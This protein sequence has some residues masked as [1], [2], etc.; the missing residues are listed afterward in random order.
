MSLFLLLFICVCVN[1]RLPLIDT[2]VQNILINFDLS[3][4]SRSEVDRALS[5]GARIGLAPGGI[6]EMFEGYPKSG[7]L[8][9]EECV[10][11]NSR[12]GFIRMALKHNLPVVPI[13]CFG[14][15][16]LMRRLHFP[17]LE[18]MSNLLRVSICIF[19]GVC[20]L[21]IPFRKKLLY[22]VGKPI[23]PPEVQGSLD[24]GSPEFQR[25]VDEMHF[26][27]CESMTNLFEK[28]K[29]SYG[30]EHKILRIV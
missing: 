10:I 11:L 28:Y 9:N 27:F 22:V 24:I 2:D 5:E 30:W 13:Y 15:S 12:K 7:R 23:H 21:P 18:K 4:A 29:S 17:F 1:D 26:N 3:D 25:Q 14:S 8:L 16:A 20:G 19:Y 6:S